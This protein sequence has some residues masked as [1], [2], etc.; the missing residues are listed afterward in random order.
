M[1]TKIEKKKKHGTAPLPCLKYAE[2][3]GIFRLHCWPYRL[4]KPESVLD[5]KSKQLVTQLAFF[6]RVLKY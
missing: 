2:A 6:H 4:G 3:F 5:M 1:A